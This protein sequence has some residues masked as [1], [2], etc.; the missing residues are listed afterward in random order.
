MCKEIQSAS[1]RAAAIS[2]AVAKTQSDRLS[3]ATLLLD[4]AAALLRLHWHAPSTSA[5]DT[6]HPDQPA[7]GEEAL[8]AIGAQLRQAL[9]CVGDLD[10]VDELP[11]EPVRAPLWAAADLIDAAA[12]GGRMTAPAS[13]GV[14]C[15]VKQAQTALYAVREAV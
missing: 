4:Q 7:L 3:E 11:I 9:D 2:G 8:A 6:F 5:P 1:A 14:S 10:E 13:W 15:L 12:F